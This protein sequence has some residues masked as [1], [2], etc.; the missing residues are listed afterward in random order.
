MQS[1]Q[2]ISK[3]SQEL[4]SPQRRPKPAVPKSPTL[5]RVKPEEQ[6][7]ESED[8][9]SKPLPPPKPPVPH[10]KRSTSPIARPPVQ[11]EDVHE[12]IN[13]REEVEKQK[14]LRAQ[15][16]R[17]EKEK[18]KAQ[19]ESAR[20]QDE[21]D[22]REHAQALKELEKQLLAQHSKPIVSAPSEEV[23]VVE[24]TPEEIEAQRQ[25][26]EKQ[27]EIREQNRKDRETREQALRDT[28]LQQQR[29]KAE[30]DR[31]QAIANK[32]MK[33]QKE[34]EEKER[35]EIEEKERKEK[36]EKFRKEKAEKERVE[37]AQRAERE[38]EEA[39]K[40]EKEEKE[41]REK[42]DK[43]RKEREEKLKKEKEEKER[44]EKEEKDKKMREAKDKK[45]QAEK[46]KRE[47]EEQ[48]RKEKEAKESALKAKQAQESAKVPSQEEDEDIPP[49]QE[50]IVDDEDDEFLM[51]DDEVIDPEPVFSPPTHTRVIEKD[52]LTIKPIPVVDQSS[53]LPDLDISP[54][55]AP[56]STTTPATQLSSREL[57][58]KQKDVFGALDNLFSKKTI[59][60]PNPVPADEPEK[61]KREPK[62][63]EH[64]MRF[65]PQPTPPL[66]LDQPYFPP[67]VH[68]TVK[69]S[70]PLSVTPPAQFPYLKSKY[71]AISQRLDMEERND[72]DPLALDET[73][74][75]D[76]REACFPPEE[77]E[78]ERS[79]DFGR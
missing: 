62:P 55:A 78:E 41:K 30:K 64:H 56:T 3:P 23:V 45:E 15:Q 29:E 52:T 39:E 22:K 76:I 9:E 47:K 18:W 38:K 14:K 2:S 6:V 53:T 66:V 49:P 12:E 10:F 33:E 31:Q 26:E 63:E 43:A 70:V 8:Q 40:K 21:H 28:L 46:L 36:I 48:K 37:K 73:P 25:L 60:T 11:T 79:Y 1:L 75:E 65:C 58:A 5:K 61:P 59:L 42:A 27:R 57:E 72:A 35:K 50:E 34:K 13:R 74:V 16:I 77:I 17:E 20:Q 7:V 44:R 68:N 19:S 54:I 67:V 32:M 4:P 51:Y 71:T 24:K 69:P